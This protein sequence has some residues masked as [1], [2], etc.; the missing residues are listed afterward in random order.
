MA[1]D[2]VVF[3]VRESMQDGVFWYGANVPSADTVRAVICNM[4]G[5]AQTAITDLP[6]R[7]ITFR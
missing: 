7:I 4:S 6:V 2:A 1:G 3:S 5:V